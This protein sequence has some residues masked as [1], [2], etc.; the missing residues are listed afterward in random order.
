MT[1]TPENK[2]TEAQQ[3]KVLREEI[4][5]LDAE[6]VVLLNR[7]AAVAL[8]VKDVKKGAKLVTYAPARERE[9][10]E[11]VLELSRGGLFPKDALE[12]IFLNIVSASR[13][14]QGE[15]TVAY[16]G[17]RSSSSFDAALRKFGRQVSM[18]PETNIGG[19]FERVEAGIANYGVVPLE[20]LG[21][22][23]VANTLESF[24]ESSVQAVGEVVSATN[25]LLLGL[26]AGLDKI[27][28]VFADAQSVAAAEKW[29]SANL[30]DVTVEVVANADLAAKRA[31]EV[32]TS[33]AIGSEFL[34]ETYHLAVLARGVES[35]T[36]LARYVV[37]GN[38]ELPPSGRDKTAVLCSIHDRPGALLEILQPF[39]Q[40]SITLTKIESRV[41]LASREHYYFYLDFLGHRNDE[42]VKQALVELSAICLSVKV[43]GSYPL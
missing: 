37:I 19:V 42:V 38:Q 22:G 27:D 2:E 9:V 35:E 23:L 41:M 6:M 24:L 43:L 30:P 18:Q 4:D 34:A 5:R 36:G 7:R 14:L 28:R 16:L 1:I 20:T 3:L 26:V 13:S 8:Q 39:A 29:L 33:A 40:G 21:G 25:L 17:P 10:L 12:R 15:Q 11:R 31:L 32:R